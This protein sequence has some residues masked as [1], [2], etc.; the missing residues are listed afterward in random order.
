MTK[1]I[2]E[3]AVLV[4]KQH[5]LVGIMTQA[6]TTA[7]TLNPTVVIL[8]TG[9]VHRVGHHRMF[10]TLSRALAS[11][12]FNVLRFDF[13][14][15]GDS[16]PRAD[17]LSPLDSSLADLDEV[18]DWLERERGGSRVVLIGLCSGADHAILHA[19]TD[20]RVAALVLMDPSI[21][22]TVRFYAQYILRH[23]SRL[24]SYLSVLF[25]RSGLLRMW[26]GDLFYGFRS[27][28]ATRPASLEDL[29][30]HKHLKECYRKAID[31]GVRILAVFTGETTRQTYR[32]Q[33]FDAF[34]DIEFGD[35]LKLEFFEG[36][37]HVFT[38]EKDR[39]R[40]YD[41]ILDWMTTNQP[42]PAAPQISA[43]E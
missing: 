2:S 40:L 33:M 7:P 35:Q 29:R 8:N 19:H 36:T 6:V 1:R 31:G 23:L 4:G 15:I 39:A 22:T 18:L 14:G 5:S 41:T 3:Q 37:D 9:I 27:K 30:F 32:E 24:R 11:A 34:P 20:H 17:S 16:E 10:V 21:P 43:A 26:I 13:A 42:R 25:L 38:S 28:P 12:G